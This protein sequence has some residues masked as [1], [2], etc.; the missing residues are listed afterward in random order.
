MFSFSVHFLSTVAKRVL[1]FK[2]KIEHLL[3]QENDLG[4]Y[5]AGTST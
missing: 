2:S 4:D 3:H 1:K 5:F